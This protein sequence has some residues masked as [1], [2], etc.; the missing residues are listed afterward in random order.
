M[1]PKQ[2]PLMFGC[3]LEDAS[4]EEQTMMLSSL[5][6]PVRLLMRAWGVR[7]YRRYITRVRAA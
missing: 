2:L 6:V 1:S 7:H 4:P 3:I 5:P